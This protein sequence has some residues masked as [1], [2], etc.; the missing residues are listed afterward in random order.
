MSSVDDNYYSELD[1]NDWTEELDSDKEDSDP[2][3]PDV[4]AQTHY[5][6]SRYFRL[7][8]EYDNMFVEETGLYCRLF[9]E[10][11]M[12]WEEDAS[13]WRNLMH[14]NPP[15]VEDS[16]RQQQSKITTNIEKPEVG[17]AGE[18]AI[19]EPSAD[20]PAFVTPNGYEAYHTAASRFLCDPERGPGILLKLR[21]D[22]AGAYPDV[23]TIAGDVKSILKELDI[24]PESIVL[25][26]NEQKE[27][28]GVALLLVESGPARDPLMASLDK[29]A[30]MDDGKT[31]SFS[32]ARLLDVSRSKD[33][34]PFYEH[35]KVMKQK[36]KPVVQHQA[37]PQMQT[38]PHQEDSSTKLETLIGHA[39]TKILKS[40]RSGSRLADLIN[41]RC[42]PPPLT[43]ETKKGRGRAVLRHLANALLSGKIR[44]VAFDAEHAIVEKG[45]N[46]I[47]L[48][49]G[50]HEVVLREDSE[51]KI[52]FH[53]FIHPGD[54][55]YKEGCSVLLPVGVKN[56][57]LT[58][59]GG[60]S[61]SGCP[62]A[63]CATFD[64][65]A[66]QCYP[67]QSFTPTNPSLLTAK[68]ASIGGGACDVAVVSAKLVE[69]CRREA[70]DV[71][72]DT[73]IKLSC[74]MLPGSHAIPLKQ[75]RLLVG[76]YLSI[77]SDI[78]ERVGFALPRVHSVEEAK[79]EIPLTILINEGGA[80]SDLHALRWVYAASNAV[81]S[82]DFNL[83]LEA[84]LDLPMFDLAAVESLVREALTAAGKW[85]DDLFKQRAAKST[86]TSECC[87][88]HRKIL[89]AAK[90]YREAMVGDDEEVKDAWRYFTL[91][92]SLESME[93]NS[94]HCALLDS[95]NLKTRLEECLKHITKGV[96]VV[97]S[98]TQ[99]HEPE[100]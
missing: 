27:A 85:E 29:S 7:F 49:F 60:E 81:S 14:V 3:V 37:Q 62:Q 79:E 97:G 91:D 47:P 57:A 43:E 39:H 9:P 36:K 70:G 63:L 20:A 88:Y 17:D 93:T 19:G 80:V 5:G 64:D 23:V 40:L 83:S 24:A 15:L 92:G 59:G 73:C 66:L 45:S 90:S 30:S 67:E 11:F 69:E 38:P 44:F 50:F 4:V 10:M 86:H 35:R 12:Q 31:L 25:G 68:A 46:A 26:F 22:A 71:R 28:S 21:K 16:P 76:D 34:L 87:W 48:E 99:H 42:P 74:C 2:E 53:T 98:S 95:F 84:T 32:C 6:T 54:L 33:T 89:D 8:N 55:E 100:P 52:P 82:T 94:P 41:R 1:P 78:A 58:A 56:S 75:S 51:E 18:A 96:N 65:L 61:R 13:T 72:L 77:C